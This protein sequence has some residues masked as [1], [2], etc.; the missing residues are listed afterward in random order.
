M[1]QSLP[2]SMSTT[3][4]ANPRRAAVQRR[5]AMAIKVMVAILE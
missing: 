2:V 3:N 5:K 4:Q 1:K